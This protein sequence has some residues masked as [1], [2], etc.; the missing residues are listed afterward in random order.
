M[1]KRAYVSPLL[2]AEQTF[3]LALEGIDI[4]YEKTEDLREKKTGNCADILIDEFISKVKPIKPP[5]AV[6]GRFDHLDWMETDEDVQNRAKTALEHMLSVDDSDCVIRV[7]HSLLIQNNLKSLEAT[8]GKTH[9][10]EK[11]M[12]A[13]G[14]LFAYVIEGDKATTS[15]GEK[16][17][18]TKPETVRRRDS[19]FGKPEAHTQFSEVVIE[20]EILAALDG[21]KKLDSK[22]NLN[23]NS[24]K[25]DSK[26][27]D[28]RNVDSK[29][30]GKRNN[31]RSILK[32]PQ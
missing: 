31:A 8:N 22:N 3:D 12:L 26:K 24:K 9:M 29:N 17:K 32:R 15:G 23:L 14:G 19:A 1:P 6:T 4:E 20:P 30:D 16:R 25:V 2:R 13:E 7:T 10:L 5:Q 27:V 11:F 28:S 18:A 21:N